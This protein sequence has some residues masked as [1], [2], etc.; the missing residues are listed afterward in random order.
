ML[1]VLESR[2][3]KCMAYFSNFCFASIYIIFGLNLENGGSKCGHRSAVVSF[4]TALVL[5]GFLGR[6]IVNMW[7]IPITLSFVVCHVVYWGQSVQDRPMVCIKKL[8][9]NV[10]STFRLVPLSTAYA[11]STPIQPKGARTGGGWLITWH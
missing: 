2:V 11:H 4:R 1:T 9:R 10:K 5:V 8:N 3:K 6:S 7:P